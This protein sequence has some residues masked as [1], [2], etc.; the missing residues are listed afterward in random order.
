MYRLFLFLFFITLNSVMAQENLYDSYSEYRE[1]AFKQHRFSHTDMEP[2]ILRWKSTDFYEIKEAGKS[3]EKRPIYLISAGKGP[4]QVLL[5]SQ[6]HGDESTATMALFDVLN[7]LYKNREQKHVQDLLASCTIHFVPMLNPDGAERFRRRNAQQID[8]N[9][10]ALRLQTPE[11]R[12]LKHLRDSLQAD[13]GFNLHDQSRY[14]NVEG[15]NK[16]ATLSFLAPAYNFKKEVNPVRKR[17]MQL[18]VTINEE[19]QKYAPGRVGKYSD[20]FEPR[21]FGDNIQKWGTSTIL[22][23]SGGYPEDPEKQTIRKLN[24]IAIIKALEAIA[25]GEYEQF[26]T[27]DYSQIPDNDRQLVGLKITGVT[28]DV[29]GIDYITDIGMVHQHVGNDSP[30]G[31]YL[32][33]E[34]EDVGD[35]STYY[36][37]EEFDASGMKLLL[38]KI[39]PEVLPDIE[40]VKSL[41]APELLS[42][43]YGYIRVKELPDESYSSLPFNIISESYEIDEELAPGQNPAFFLTSQGEVKYAVINGFLVPVGDSNLTDVQGLILRK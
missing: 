4:T 15:T 20:E 35:L 23:E 19:I 5:W 34:I 24:F 21:A 22:I 18:I 37:Y 2:V 3:L 32:V 8:I 30:L 17:A 38:A 36:G 10:D 11:G 40:S 29:M 7:Y 43:G 31:Y 14:Y 39:Y 26:S 42:K 25:S 13:F 27:E 28:H 1:P 12:L 16:T 41:N 33:A 9:R 6:M